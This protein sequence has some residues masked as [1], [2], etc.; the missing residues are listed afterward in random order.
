MTAYKRALWFYRL[1]YIGAGFIFA[2]GFFLFVALM[3]Q[4]DTLLGGGL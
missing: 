2:A 1:Q 3:F 4:L